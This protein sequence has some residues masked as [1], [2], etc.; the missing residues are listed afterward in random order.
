MEVPEL[1]FLGARAEMQR[2]VPSASVSRYPNLGRCAPR[3]PGFCPR[4]FLQ[5]VLID[6]SYGSGTV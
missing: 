1:G 3:K 4:F 6:A 2:A 5:P